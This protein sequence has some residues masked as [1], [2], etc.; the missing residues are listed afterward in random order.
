MG[1]LHLMCLSL[2]YP[3][4]SHTL[5]LH[6]Y[7]GCLTSEAACLGPEGWAAPQ[8][9]G[10][11]VFEAVFYPAG[12]HFVWRRQCLVFLPISRDELPSAAWWWISTKTGFKE[13]GHPG[14]HG[15]R[16]GIQAS[17]P[18]LSMTKQNRSHAFNIS[19]Q[20]SAQHSGRWWEGWFRKQK[21]KSR[22]KYIF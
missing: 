4:A 17:P 19:Q 20:I 15:E 3:G 16:I 1:F 8:L 22:R 7:F 18:T 2:F 9:T 21:M 5:F 10:S 6:H 14:P 11:V 12:F 13:E